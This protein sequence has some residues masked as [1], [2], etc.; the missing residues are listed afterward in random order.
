MLRK[1]I[2][3]FLAVNYYEVVAVNNGVDGLRAVLNEDFD[4]IICDMVMPKLPGHLFYL[5]V[6]RM[7]PHLCSRLI[8]MEPAYADEST[9]NDSHR[10]T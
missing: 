10:N 5:S 1:M 2:E 8:F 4:F 6:K 3:E 9:I 7:K